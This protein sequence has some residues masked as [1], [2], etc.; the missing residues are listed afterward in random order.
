MQ[1]IA[2]PCLLVAF[3]VLLGA[4]IAAGG[5]SCEHL[6]DVLRRL[7]F[8]ARFSG[9]VLLRLGAGGRRRIV[10]LVFLDRLLRSQW[11]RG[12]R[13]RSRRCVA[14]RAWRSAPRA[15]RELPEGAGKLGRNL[16]AAFPTEDLV[17]GM[18][19]QGDRKLWM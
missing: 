4:D 14:E 19:S 8:E 1:L 5:A 7:T 12:R 11:R 3:A 2:D 15:L 18:R 17:V 6:A 13:A 10:F 16:H 9:I